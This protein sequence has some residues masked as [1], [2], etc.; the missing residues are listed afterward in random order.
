MLAGA[1]LLPVPFAAMFAAPAALAP[2]ASA[3]WTGVA[4]LLC[5]ATY[6]LFQVP[7]VSMPAEMTDDYHERTTVVSYRIVALTLGILAAGAAAPLLVERAGGGRR[8]Y[9]VMG[10]AIALFQMAGMLGAFAGTRR[11]PTARR[12]GGA[13]SL[14]AALSAARRNR[15]FLSLWLCFVVQALATA[16]TLAAI[17]YFGKYILGRADATTPLFCGIVAP[18]VVVMPLWTLLAR[19]AGKKRVY[20]IASLLYAAASLGLVAGAALPFP[21]V[22]SLVVLAGAGYSGMQVF[23]LAMLPD[24]IAADDARTGLQRGGLLTGLWTA[25]ETAAFELGPSLV[26]ALL[27]FAGFVSSADGA[28]P[29]PP[30]A[31]AGIL[32][33]FGALPGLTM[34]VSLLFLRGYDLDEKKL[35]ALVAQA[36]SARAA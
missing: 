27:A 18:A 15:W 11:A 31:R 12:P 24:T 7:Y 9:L 21:A 33:A 10:V 28:A 19:R 32:L 35:A 29:Q 3:L 36:P 23:P 16:A 26:G 13:G 6:A 25:G 4:F 17:P 2:A 14:P 8:G 34:V 22:M 1:L 5:A 30:G 20:V